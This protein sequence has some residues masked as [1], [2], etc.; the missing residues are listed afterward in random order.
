[1]VDGKWKMGM[2]ESKKPRWSS[3]ERQV[4]EEFV[5]L[6]RDTFKD[7]VRRIILYGSRARGDADEESD[8]DFL[9][10]LEPW[11]KQD[12]EILRELAHE[13]FKRYYAVIFARAIKESDFCEDRYFYFYENVCE[14]GIDL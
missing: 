3:E 9:V 7:R 4:I 11:S 5:S 8:Y 14:E 12:Q 1:M 2:R 13:I 10:L 6:V